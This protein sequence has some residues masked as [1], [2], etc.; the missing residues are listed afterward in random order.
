M[1]TID[2]FGCQKSIASKI[3]TLGA[4]YMIA[5]KKNQHALTSEVENFF[6]QVVLAPEYAPCV[7]CEN[8]SS[9][10]GRHDKQEVWVSHEIDWLPQLKEWTDLKSIVMVLRRWEKQGIVHEEKRY[11]IAS[12]KASAERTSQLVRRHWSIENELHWHLDVTFKED[13]SQIDPESNENLR[14]ARMIALDMLVNETTFKRGLK[15]KMRSC[16]RSEDYL[17]QVLSL[18]KF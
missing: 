11:Y 12:F 18:E 1:I 10:N 15:A 13:D 9:S 7:S 14:V 2:D 6:D 8:S 3:R 16:H 5:L 4:D 17:I